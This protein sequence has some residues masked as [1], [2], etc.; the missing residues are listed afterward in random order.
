[1]RGKRRHDGV[2]PASA[3]PGFSS[4]QLA[5]VA[6]AWLVVCAIPAL[7]LFIRLRRA[8]NPIPEWWVALT[9]V[10]G[11]LGL[12]AYWGDAKREERRGRKGAEAREDSP[13]PKAR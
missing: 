5:W 2:E 7:V 3:H 12:L 1:M 6:L 4:G 11:P 13:R 9:L 8:K 10:A